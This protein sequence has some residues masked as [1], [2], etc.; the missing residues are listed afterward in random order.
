MALKSK[1]ADK[2]CTHS[3]KSGKMEEKVE[4]G[5]ERAWALRYRI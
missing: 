1:N 3:T 4:D 2:I 5:G